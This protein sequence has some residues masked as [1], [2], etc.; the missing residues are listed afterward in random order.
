MKVYEKDFKEESV[1]L[2]YEIG[3]KKAAEQLLQ[4]RCV[5]SII[6]KISL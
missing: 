2:S 6:S 1:K 3:T 5:Q 4:F